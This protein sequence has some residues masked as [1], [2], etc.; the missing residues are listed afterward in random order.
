M[1][2]HTATT[3]FSDRGSIALTV[4][5]ATTAV[6]LAYRGIDDDNHIRYFEC[7]WDGGQYLRT[8]CPNVSTESRMMITGP[9]GV[10]RNYYI[11]IGTTSRDLG[12]LSTPHSFGVRVVNDIPTTSQADTWTFTI[13]PANIGIWGVA[14]GYLDNIISTRH[15]TSDRISQVQFSY[16]RSGYSEIQCSNIILG[17]SNGIGQPYSR[18][19]PN[20]GGDG[21]TIRDSPFPLHVPNTPATSFVSGAQEYTLCI[22]AAMS[23]GVVSPPGCFTYNKLQVIIPTPNTDIRLHL[24]FTGQTYQISGFE[25]PSYN[26]AHGNMLWSFGASPVAMHPASLRALFGCKWDTQQYFSPCAPTQSMIVLAHQLEFV[27]YWGDDVV[28]G[29]SDGQHHLSVRASYIGSNPDPTPAEFTWCV[30]GCGPSIP[31]VHGVTGISLPGG[32]ST[33]EA[34]QANQTSPIALLV[35]NAGPDRIVPENTTVTLNGNASAFSL[36]NVPIN[37][38]VRLLPEALKNLQLSWAWTQT[39]GPMVKLIDADK[40]SNHT[41]KSAASFIAPLLDKDTKLSFSL[42][43]KAT[44]GLIK[45]VSD[46]VDVLVMNT[47]KLISMN[48]ANNTNNT[49]T[50]NISSTQTEKE[51]VKSPTVFQSNK[52]PANENITTGFNNDAGNNTANNNKEP[53][54][55]FIQEKPFSNLTKFTAPPP[56]PSSSFSNTPSA[57]FN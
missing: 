6:T 56:S 55:Q 12:V 48:N 32:G 4:D 40:N 23:S 36:L 17:R 49:N 37:Q 35:A 33:I 30:N 29:I 28:E 2:A 34:I 20:I 7:S 31:I 27:P 44:K 8:N 9:D 11:R 3:S 26:T 5:H 53:T 15:T 54:G 42:N 25:P 46:S 18:C 52:K 10:L 21:G 45:S 51:I 50:N 13:S 38:T 47:T 14:D 19:F 16:P 41:T 1:E 39:A 43:V 22:R 57:G 24:P